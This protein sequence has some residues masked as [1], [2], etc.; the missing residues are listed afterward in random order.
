MEMVAEGVSLVQVPIPAGI[1]CLYVVRG[2]QVAVI[3]TG[4]AGTPQEY[5]IPAL[6]RVGLGGLD[7][8]D[9]ILNTHG[10]PD[11][12]G[13]NA[14]CQVATGA[15]IALHRADV[16]LAGGWGAHVLSSTDP[17]AAMRLLGLGADL[18]ERE[19]FLR[20]RVRECRVDRI[21]E[22]GDLIDL[23]K[24]RQLLVVHTPGHTQG[25]VAFVDQ[26]RGQ[27]F[28][29]DAIQGWGANDHALP[30][31]FDPHAYASSLRRLLGL[32]L[33][34]V[35][36]GHPFCWSGTSAPV[37]RGADVVRIIEDSLSF[38]QEASEAAQG[39]GENPNDLGFEVMRLLERLEPP[40]RG[41]RIT[42]AV[43]G[44]LL[45]HLANR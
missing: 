4:Y 21:L 35:Y 43:A 44:T 38:V 26:K 34:S 1:V 7:E 19:D 24:E 17:C 15:K 5:L 32:D 25:S 13:G 39:A 22:D 33:Q 23:G 20:E 2:Q 31:Y 14:A 40:F 18:R 41:K 42:P 10:H 6:S 30:L 3:D 28:T 45:A 11:H 9:Y 27:A 12:L 8:V 36:L 37:L 16:Y 29:G